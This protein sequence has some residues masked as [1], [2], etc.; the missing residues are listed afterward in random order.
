M[1][2]R[3]CLV[4]IDERRSLIGRALPALDDETGRW[5]RCRARVSERHVVRRAQVFAFGP[6]ATGRHTP[7]VDG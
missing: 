2:N 6:V 3:A 5:R 7:C 4:R 1:A